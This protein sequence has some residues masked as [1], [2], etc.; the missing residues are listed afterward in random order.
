MPWKGL[1]NCNCTT[2]QRIQGK[3]ESLWLVSIFLLVLTGD[4][5]LQ[6]SGVSFN[7]KKLGSVSGPFAADQRSTLS[8]RCAQWLVVVLSG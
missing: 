3:K 7:A 6:N 8:A 2:K 5:R 4:P 1:E